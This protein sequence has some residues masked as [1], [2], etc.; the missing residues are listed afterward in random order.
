MCPHDGAL[1]CGLLLF[2]IIAVQ[3]KAEKNEYPWSDM[4]NFYQDKM[5]AQKMPFDIQL[6][7]GAVEY[8]FAAELAVIE[9]NAPVEEV[10]RSEERRVGKECR[11]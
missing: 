9:K 10:Y 3:K 11:L 6:Y 4:F 1:L 8:D 7:S 2:G 5:L